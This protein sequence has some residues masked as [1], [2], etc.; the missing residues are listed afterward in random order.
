MKAMPI[1]PT[2]S[3]TNRINKPCFPVQKRKTR[4]DRKTIDVISGDSPELLEL[5]G[6][7]HS[8]MTWATT[9]IT[10]MID[11]ITVTIN[12]KM[13]NTDA[14]HPIC[15]LILNI[16]VL[17]VTIVILLIATSRIRVKKQERK[18]AQVKDIPYLAPATTI[19]VTLPV[20]IT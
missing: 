2:I 12:P 10:P 8:C 20:P 19:E 15:F 3:E 16:M 5:K 1:T 11:E 9:A 18:S 6:L 14:N 17:P 7:L 4:K 13:I